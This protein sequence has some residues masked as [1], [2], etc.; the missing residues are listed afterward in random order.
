MLNKHGLHARPTAMFF[1]KIV[2]P[3]GKALDLIFSVDGRGEF[4]IKGVFDLMALGLEKGTKILIKIA[5]DRNSDL[6]SFS[7]SEPEMEL[8]ERAYGL[9][10]SYFEERDS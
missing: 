3:H 7:S 8:A 10:S 5:Y 1:E 6:S 9:F 4:P 2:M